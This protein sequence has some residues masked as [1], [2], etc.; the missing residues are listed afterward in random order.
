MHMKKTALT[1][2][3]LLALPFVASA[4]TGQLQNIG[5][6]VV[7]I[8]SIVALLIPILI[9]LALVVFFW[10]LV[11][12]IWGGGKDTAAG[13]KIMIAGIISLFVM[14]SIYGIIYFAQLSLFGS[15]SQTNIYI[16]L[17][18]GQTQ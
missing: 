5:D 14:I 18:P 15:A 16:P 10:G 1:I 4:A 13:K 6:L 12:Y 3:T 7:A 2:A 17:Y 11:K 8:G 9:A